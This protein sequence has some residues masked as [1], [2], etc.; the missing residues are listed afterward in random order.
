M[1]K[2]IFVLLPDGIGIRNFVFTD[3]ADIGKDNG[4]DTVYWNNT[5]N[6]LSNLGYKECKIQNA[7][8]HPLTDILKKAKIQIALNQFIKKTNDK[9][10][11]T[12]R[13]TPQNGT[14]KFK[15]KNFAV[16]RII[17]IFNSKKG[18][19]S[20]SNYITTLER[21]TDFYKQCFE[22]LKAEKPAFV[23]CTMFPANL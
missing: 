21:K 15:I 23:F 9:V 10:F 8:L 4:C 1:N 7:K 6:D 11:D 5:D 13:F 20:I 12:Y 3:F 17:K 19:I 22:T 14:L 16:R 2:K 18:L